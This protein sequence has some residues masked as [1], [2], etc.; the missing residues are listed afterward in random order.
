MD[1]TDAAVCNEVL[2]SGR[3][4]YGNCVEHGY[5]ALQANDD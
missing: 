1:I 2:H 5:P 3:R 4:L